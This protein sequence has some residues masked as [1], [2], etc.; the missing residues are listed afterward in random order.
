LWSA[1][2]TATADLESDHLLTTL[3]AHTDRIWALA[4]SPAYPLISGAADATI[5]FWTDTT[6]QTLSTLTAAASARIEQDQDL[7]NHILA[8]NYR[9]VITL[10]LQLNH[11][12]RLLRLFEDV[13]ALPAA[14]KEPGSITGVAAVDDVLVSLS[15]EQLYMLLLRVR[16]WNTNA[17]TAPVAQKVLS[18]VLRKYP[19]SMFTEMARD[20][21]LRG[22]KDLLR[23]L[24]V[25][26][27]RHFKRMDELMDESY[28]LEYTLRCMDEISGM[29]IN[30]NGEGEERDGDVLMT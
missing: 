1:H 4:T 17:R 8:K 27:E 20:R 5:T 9:E 15:R 26:T 24:E 21:S 23:A 30:G 12:G 14:E 11:P 19:G 25:Y 18:C 29:G 13:L 7:Q 10:A 22:V 28:L 6:S 3:S 16:D 2:N